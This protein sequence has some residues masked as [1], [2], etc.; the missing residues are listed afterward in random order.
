MTRMHAISLL[1]PLVL[2]LSPSSGMT[3]GENAMPGRLTIAHDANYPPFAFLDEGGTPRGYL[4]DLWRAFGR[5]NDINIDFKLGTWQESLDMVKSGAA[6]GHGGL[7]FSAE[8]DRFLDYGPTIMEVAAYMYVNNAL[9]EEIAATYPVGVV[10]GGFEEHFM[11][12]EWPERPL[13]LF[14]QNKAMIQAAKDGMLEV[15]VADQPTAVHYLNLFHIGNDFNHT[16]K[17]YAMPMRVAVGE[18]RHDAL[19]C[20]LYGW[21]KLDQREIKRIFGTW[22]IHEKPTPDWWWPGL[23]ISLLT[24]VAAIIIRKL[25]RRAH[26]V[27]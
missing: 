14:D 15:F 5:A 8:R 2:F 22:F 6:D 23:L 24:I 27:Q 21:T 7:F 13:V 26:G 18:G 20:I 9:S 25:G 3:E 11:R 16:R 10:K 19:D 1:I 4:I 17:L 12:T